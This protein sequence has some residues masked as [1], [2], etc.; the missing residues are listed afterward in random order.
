[1]NALTLPMIIS[2]VLAMGASGNPDAAKTHHQEEELTAA[3]DKLSGSLWGTLI[4]GATGSANGQNLNHNETIVHDPAA[5]K[6][7]R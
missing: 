1:M 2:M 7:P 5:N 4:G 6:Q 3:K